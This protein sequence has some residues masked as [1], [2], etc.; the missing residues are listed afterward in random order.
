VHFLGDLQA[1]RCQ[2][3][4]FVSQILRRR[5]ILFREQIIHLNCNPI[6]AKEQAAFGLSVP[7]TNSGCSCFSAPLGSLQLNRNRIFDRQRIALACIDLTVRERA[8]PTDTSLP[9]LICQIWEPK[10]CRRLGSEL[11]EHPTD[12]HHHTLGPASSVNHVAL[13]G[14]ALEPK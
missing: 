8:G 14:N 1:R 13:F 3:D 9:K 4:Y 6:S 2:P 10:S 5:D 11:A 7:R 12:L